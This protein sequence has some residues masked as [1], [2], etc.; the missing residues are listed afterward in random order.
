MVQMT[1]RIDTS[2]G[3]GIKTTRNPLF[4]LK[5]QLGAL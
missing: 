1:F 2:A 4:R 3:Y 5:I